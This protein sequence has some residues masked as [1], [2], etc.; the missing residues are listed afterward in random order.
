MPTIPGADQ[1]LDLIETLTSTVRQFAEREGK[2]NYALKLIQNS[3]SMPDQP[4]GVDL[5]EL[6]MLAA[7]AKEAFEKK[8]SI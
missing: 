2:L 5:K 1:I 3:L 8:H 6:S 7:E 4:L